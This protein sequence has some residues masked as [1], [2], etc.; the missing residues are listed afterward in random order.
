MD[1][2]QT[3]RI[4]ELFRL[5]AL[6]TPLVLSSN[7]VPDFLG[8]PLDGTLWSTR[9]NRADG[10]FRQNYV[11]TTG[12]VGILPLLLAWVGVCTRRNGSLFFVGLAAVTLLLVMGTPLLEI[13][14]L[15]P[16]FNFSRID[17]LVFLYMFAVGF[18]GACGISALDDQFDRIAFPKMRILIPIV[19]L[20]ALFWVAFLLA[21]HNPDLL[22]DSI[23]KGPFRPLAGWEDVRWGVV[24]TGTL[25]LAGAGV[26]GLRV[27]NG[28]SRLSYRACVL[29]LL[30]IDLLP[31]G[32]RFNISRPYED[33]FPPTRMTDQLQHAPEPRRVMRFRK[34][35]LFSN[36]AGVYGI[37]DAQGYNALTARGKSL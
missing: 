7:L 11:S 19:A 35:V 34:D 5:V 30:L 16:G 36:T 17:R 31:F 13:A 29:S 14:Y 10:Y 2:A 20:V 18:L 6:I 21:N 4:H 37:S 1:P 3:Q 8:N 22:Y 26:I 32:Y 9:F 23:I 24:K 15:F 28:L 12:Y 25:L 27:W 33:A